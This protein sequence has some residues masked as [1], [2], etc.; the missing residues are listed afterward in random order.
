MPKPVRW[1]RM[2]EVNRSIHV[3]TET[4]AAQPRRLKH[5]IAWLASH[6]LGSHKQVRRYARTNGVKPSSDLRL[7]KKIKLVAKLKK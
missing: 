4:Y 7:D 5:L 3:G 6:K 1:G 2:S